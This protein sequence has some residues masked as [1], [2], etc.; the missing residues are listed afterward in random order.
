[1]SKTNE[2]REATE[3]EK[4]NVLLVLRFDKEGNEG[5]LLDKCEAVMVRRSDNPNVNN[6]TD[7][8]QIIYAQPSRTQT[9]RPEEIANLHPPDS[10]DS[11]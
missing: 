8:F 4:P 11:K 5:T 2:I 10:S 3:E 1:M 6:W 9:N 7:N